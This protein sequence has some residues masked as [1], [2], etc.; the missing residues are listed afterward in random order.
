MGFIAAYLGGEVGLVVFGDFAG[1][2][3]NQCA[4]NGIG[5]I[6]ANYIGLISFN[7]RC[8]AA[9]VFGH[10]AF[11]GFCLIS[12]NGHGTIF[13]Y[14]FSKAV[15]VGPG[16]CTADFF[17]EGAGNFVSLISTY[18]GG[19]VFANGVSHVFRSI[20]Y[21]IFSNQSNIC[22]GFSDGG[23]IG[24]VSDVLADFRCLLYCSAAISC[25]VRNIFVN[26]TCGLGVVGFA[27]A[28]GD[29]DAVFGA[30]LGSIADIS[31]AVIDVLVHL[32]RSLG[33]VGIAGT[34]GYIN[35]VL[36]S[37]LGYCRSVGA[38]FYSIRNGSGGLD[39]AYI[40]TYF[41][42]DTVG[43][44]VYDILRIEGAGLAN[45]SSLVLFYRFD[46]AVHV[47]TVSCASDGFIIG[48]AYFMNFISAYCGGE[49]FT[50]GMSFIIGNRSREVIAN[51]I[52]HIV[53]C[54]VDQVFGSIGDCAIGCGTGDIF[55]ILNNGSGSGAVS[56]FGSGG[57]GSLGF[58]ILCLSVYAGNFFFGSD[59]ATF[60]GDA[61]AIAPFIGGA[62]ALQGFAEAISSLGGF[63]GSRSV[64]YGNAASVF[65]KFGNTGM[66]ISIIIGKHI[67]GGDFAA[68]NIGIVVGIFFDTEL[69][70][71]QLAI[72][73]EISAYI[74]IFFKGS[75]F[76]KSRGAI[77][78]RGAGHFQA[79]GS[80]LAINGCIAGEY[81]IT[82]F[83]ISIGADDIARSRNS[84]VRFQRAYFSCI[85]Y[86]QGFT[87][88]FSIRFDTAAFDCT[89][90]SQSGSIDISIFNGSRAISDL[91][92]FDLS[93]SGDI[94]ASSDT[95][96]C[97]DIAFVDLD[98]I[99][100]AKDCFA[101][102][103]KV[104]FHGYFIF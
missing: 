69:V 95:F 85:G 25:T 81:A 102:D 100:G 61:S 48:A 91:R 7:S 30:S 98:L 101:I 71:I 42:G 52:G 88:K 78:S 4:G 90:S 41:V 63:G 5:L 37:R 80:S 74:Y 56:N 54:I 92:A 27:S 65:I 31:I 66:N 3:F 6:A 94:S 43:S 77:E 104:I 57:T 93:V 87:G 28:I 36:G 17:C 12:I 22:R 60:L 64:V 21:Q 11:D 10:C 45:R 86:F 49:V 47:G 23:G 75:L 24:S 18:C 16:S 103:L 76:L 73:R 55:Y 50:Y 99:A 13:G 38:I 44:N 62:F 32:T 72:D 34:V 39:S 1:N 70:H 51:G 84:F 96:I 79:S 68:I 9:I 14:C 15:F 83:D 53:G 59:F 20:V 82:T 35:A 19:E 89:G 2:G 58:R 40:V 8:L 46:K 33:I 67:L 97:I 29:I 26:F